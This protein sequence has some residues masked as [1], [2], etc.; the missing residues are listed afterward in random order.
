MSSEKKTRTVNEFN[1]MSVEQLQNQVMI[2]KTMIDGAKREIKRKQKEIAEQEAIIKQ[3][4]NALH[5]IET[6]KSKVGDIEYT[7]ILLVSVKSEREMKY[8][9]IQHSY[10]SPSDWKS[11]L[12]YNFAVYKVNKDDFNK[13]GACLYNSAMDEKTPV[14]GKDIKYSDERGF[15]ASQK[16]ELQSAII[17]AIKVFKVTDVFFEGDVSLGK[18]DIEKLIGKPVIHKGRYDRY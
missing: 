16:K 5:R 9:N 8:P 1:G 15:R 10:Y 12:V 18:A 11:F 6:A 4:T 13:A 3:Y 17:N 7:P 14:Y 2:C